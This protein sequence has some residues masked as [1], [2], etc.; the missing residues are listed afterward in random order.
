LEVQ[1]GE[2]SRSKL[3]ELGFDF[4]S[5][6]TDN[7]NN[8]TVQ[9]GLFAGETQGPSTSLSPQTGVSGFYKFVGEKATITAAVHALQEQ[10]DLKMLATPKLL[11]LSGEKASFLAGGEIPVPVPQSGVGF[12]SYTIEW[13]EYG[14]RLGFVPTVVDS[15]LINLNVIPEVS[16]LDWSN[17]V[18]VSGFQ[19]PAM[20]TRR[21][22]T[23][24]ELNSGQTLFMG[25]LVA[26]ESLKTV[27]RIPILGH[28]PLLGAL[29]TRKDTSAREN[30]L[31]FIV[32]PRIIG[33]ASKEAVPPLPWDGKYEE[34]PADSGAGG[35]QGR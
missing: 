23:T 32:S 10:G 1:V 15:N 5:L 2:V 35:E 12:A 4:A 25:G 29:F 9:G 19:I 6:Y 3:S 16:S 24:V 26:T 7:E 20:L 17:A 13:K 18:G 30:E 11:S 14:V 33:S 31:V 21:A 27:K 22:N 28:I 34:E 8:F